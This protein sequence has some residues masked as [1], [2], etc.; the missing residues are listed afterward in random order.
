MIQL[1]YLVQIFEL[2]ILFLDDAKLIVKDTLG[3][4]YLF[5]ILHNGNLNPT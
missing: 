3:H 4:G 1:L 5:H 2:G